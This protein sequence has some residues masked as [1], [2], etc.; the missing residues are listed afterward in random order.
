MLPL[1]RRRAGSLTPLT[2]FLGLIL[3]FASTASAAVLGID[4]GTLNIKAALVK[5]GTPLDI[6]LT[7][8]SKRKE[9]A[10]VA[11]KPNRDEKNKV[12]TEEGKFPER[13]YGG[14]AL[15]LQGRLP[16]EVFPN[17]KM[18]LGLQP[19]EEGDKTAQVYK[20]RYPALQMESAAELGT[21]VFK[22]GAFPE[23]TAPFSVEE[24]VG[25][26]LANIRRN[27]E[28][29]AG[30]GSVVEHAVITIPA[31][32]TA[33]E[34]RALVK[35]AGFAGLTVDALISDGMAVGMEYAKTRTFPEVTKGEQ[36]EYHL[37]Y[38]MG[39]GSA[40]ATL[41][42]F[43]SRSVKDVGRT[44]KTVQEVAVVGAGWDRTLGGDAMNTV[45]MEDFVEKLLAKP[46]VK[47]RGTTREEITSNGRLMGRFF[48]DAEKARHILSANTETSNGFEEILPDIDLRTK[49]SRADFE[50]MT[51]DF[52]DRVTKPITE[53]LAMAKLE[54]KDLNSLIVHGGAVRT[55]F[56]QS[57]L[58]KL[59]GSSKIRSSV[60]PD[61]AA[62]FGAAFKA[63]TL[64]PSFKVKEIRD[65]E[66]AG[67]TTSLKYTD[68]GKE[69]KQQLFVPSSPVGWGATTKQV[70]FKDK[71]DFTFGFVQT[72]GEVDRPLI[73][74]K[75]EN[76]TASVQELVSKYGCDK[77]EINTK[78]GVRLSSQ[79]GLPEVSGGTVSCEVDDSKSGSVG[80]SVK[81]WLG[82]GKKKDQEPLG[83]EEAD[84][85]VEE[86]DASTSAS[87]STS[88]AAS[89]SSDAASSSKS[90]EPPKKRTETVQV[91]VTSNSEGTATSDNDF[92]VRSADRLK[93]FDDSDQARYA[94][95]EAQNVL[96]AYTYSVRDF[97]ENK[98]YDNFGTKTM[99][100][101][102]SKLLQTT[103][104]WME[105]GDISKATTEVLKEKRT[106]LRNLVEPIKT[107]KTE[108][109][110]R[111][112]LIK[113]LQKSLDDTQKLIL[114]V[115]GEAEK[116][117]S[118]FSKALSSMAATSSS[119]SSSSS[120]SSAS[121]DAE[122]LDEE[123][124]ATSTTE[125]PPA[126]TNAYENFNFDKIQETYDSISKWLTST[127]AEQN[128]LKPHEEPVLSLRDLENKAKEMA[129][130][131]QD[132]N[133]AAKEARKPPKPAPKPKAKPTKKAAKS[134]AGEKATDVPVA[135]GEEEEV[136]VPKKGE[137]GYEEFERG[138]EEFKK[139]KFA[140]INMD[141]LLGKMEKPAG[142]DEGVVHEEL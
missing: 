57:K 130:A 90:P 39:A 1:G 121:P 9:V 106:A 20:Q 68:K 115:Q 125:A 128:K 124:A 25:M 63:A 76:L 3:L 36:P 85:P 66:L 118:S 5:P 109:G 102:I 13:A 12:V 67:Y 134:A 88:S 8:D 50:K 113:S 62:V 78:F 30:R 35:A 11:F 24:L 81:G 33:D 56:V 107:R 34:R 37:V 44:N 61:E 108:E 47:Q 119:A 60:N 79:F 77:D 104:D 131:K 112:A 10:A 133:L 137:E 54:I 94:R 97:L 75:S 117:S 86:V 43:Q 18:L 89:S 136:K 38:D 58:E 64:S 92:F 65:S 40:T 70:T 48:K 27:A 101:E 53:A 91:R 7:K 99:R 127:T 51:A 46:D 52:A 31:F 96:E 28:L 32:Y 71:E 17:L 103:R 142:D 95:D 72:V 129:S 14:D 42:R 139:N 82:L 111:P 110:K 69:R 59:V 83:D 4:F 100:A 93:A 135:E 21:T 80:E 73:T 140:E 116:A 132:F 29:M 120:S 126:P 141:E 98:E 49:L 19:G 122:N 41:M 6:V 114:K 45:I 138:Y 105:S 15:S 87:T 22:S 55:P 26:E 74:A 23:T 16:G 123:D 84:G 2:L